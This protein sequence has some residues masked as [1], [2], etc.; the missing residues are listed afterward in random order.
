M[1]LLQSGR[2]E[3]ILEIKPAFY[4]IEDEIEA[5]G[6][7]LIYQFIASLTGKIIFLGTM[8]DQEQVTTVSRKLVRFHFI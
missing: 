5:N 4:V 1:Q 3:S 7:F 2:L 8:L 6:S